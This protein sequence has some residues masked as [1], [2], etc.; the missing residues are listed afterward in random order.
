MV[1][2]AVMSV[3]RERARKKKRKLEVL[4]NSA[5]AVMHLFLGERANSHSFGETERIM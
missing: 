5:L 1:D 4:A 3:R 2:L